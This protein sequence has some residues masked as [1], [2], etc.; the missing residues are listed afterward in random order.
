M[1]RK[2]PKA[3]PPVRRPPPKRLEVPLDE[4]EMIVGKARANRL[5]TEECDVLGLAVETL[6][7][8]TQELEAKGVSIRRLRKLIFG[9]RTEK[10]ANVLGEDGDEEPDAADELGEDPRSDVAPGTDASDAGE[11]GDGPTSAK[12]EK[13]KSGGKRKGHG[14]NGASAF[15][16][17]ERRGVEHPDIHH[18]DSCPLC[19]RGKVYHQIEPAKLLRVLG[20]APLSATVYELERLRCNGCGKVFTAQAPE[21]IGDEKYD[22]TATAMIALLK[23]GTG[24]P[25]HRLERLESILG[26][27]LPSST[28]W[29]LVNQAVDLVL[30]AYDELIRQAAQG[31]VVHNDDTHMK[32]LDCEPMPVDGDEDRAGIYTTGIVSNVKGQRI[33]LFFTGHHH[34]GENLAEVLARRASELAPPIQMCDGLSHNTA[35]EFVSIL[36]NCIPH[37]RRKFVDVADYFPDECRVVLEVL[38][39]VFRIDAQAKAEGL[40]AEQRLRLHQ[41]RSGPGMEK[42]EK[43]LREQLDEHKVEPNSGLGK[44]IRYMLKHWEPLTL[45]L[46]VAGAPIDNNICERALKMAILNR[47]NAMFYKTLNG[48]RTGDRYMSLIHSA[49]LAGVNSFA[50]LVGLLG[51]PKAVAADPAA[52]MPWNFEASLARLNDGRLAAER[53]T[54][55]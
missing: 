35:G 8:L 20:V 54:P 44:A 49:E 13:T 29:D 34:A 38:R 36:A 55:A 40:T 51:H 6:A 31:D 25:F 2:T 42:L 47:K 52:W 39:E 28:Q 30:P 9:S 10:T 1:G 26:I 15:S 43:W 16:G 5:S 37:A 11:E 33:A 53:E 14:R 48:A 12:S 7:F 23:Y 46:R 4:L 3:P 45:F 32:V 17:A 22:E 18:G 27:P 50:Y 24:V 21:G 41:E 19:A